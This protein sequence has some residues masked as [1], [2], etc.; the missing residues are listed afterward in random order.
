[1]NKVNEGD[2]KDK[3]K[4]MEKCYLSLEMKLFFSAFFLSFEI[5]WG[6]SE[7]GSNPMR[8]LGRKKH[9]FFIW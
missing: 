6:F 1:M 9:M 2:G 3:Q 5:N 4:K 7:I 8:A